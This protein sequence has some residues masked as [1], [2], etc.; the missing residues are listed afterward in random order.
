MAEALPVV[1]SLLVGS[2]FYGALRLVSAL[3]RAVNACLAVPTWHFQA[4][5]VSG[6][7]RFL[8]PE[9]PENKLGDLRAGFRPYSEVGSTALATIPL[10]SLK[11][12]FWFSDAEA[13]QQIVEHV[14]RFRKEMGG[15]ELIKFHG[16]NIVASEGTV[17]KRYRRAVRPSFS[18]KNYALAWDE[19]GRTLDEWF[20]SITQTASQKQTEVDVVSSLNKVT[21]NVIASAGF[22]QHF[23]WDTPNPGANQGLTLTLPV[24]IKDSIELAVWRAITPTWAYRLPV[25][26]LAKTKLAYD[27]IERHIYGIIRDASYAD[28]EQKAKTGIAPGSLLMGLLEANGTIEDELRLSDQELLSNIYV[29][30]LAGHDT[31]AHTVSFV[32]AI[33][34]LYPD[35]HAR[36]R[37]EADA[38]W[39]D[40][41]SR[42]SSIYK[43]DFPRMP[44]ALAVLHE[45]LRHFPSEPVIPRLAD[46]DTVLPARKRTSAQSPTS[47]T[48][49]EP[50]SV[51]VPKG[52]VVVP[53][54]LGMHMNTHYWGADAS[55]FDP[56]RFLAPDW[57]K[58]AYMPFASG[59]R[60][61]LGRGF[62]I[63]EAVRIIATVAQAWDVKCKE[64]MLRLSWE[65]RKRVLLRWRQ[66]VTMTPVDIKLIFTKR[67]G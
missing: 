44:Y 54:I 30:L 62:A 31:T 60:V 15:Y 67:A 8:G 56:S 14:D 32:M 64:D 46:Q 29:L 5:D 53:D 49:D 45:T 24:A 17:W 33:F 66:E 51:P 50:F 26:V 16:P 37:S 28:S 21:L 59:P 63:A 12:T 61:C 58:H 52:S 36:V 35:I 23:P 42:Q 7:L 38:V 41:T 34:A 2:L 55:E 57:P 39:P 11:P 27:E 10:E 19:A 65:E 13:C 22:G 9:W 3:Q 48:F 25:S 40:S 1:I 6:V 47:T 4:F 20:A 18:E 43:S